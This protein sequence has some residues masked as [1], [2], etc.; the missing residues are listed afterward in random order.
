MNPHAM[1]RAV[2]AKTAGELHRFYNNPNRMVAKLF[3]KRI[4][5]PRGPYGESFDPFL[6]PAV[7][8]GA[9]GMGGIVSGGFPGP[10]D[11][12][13]RTSTSGF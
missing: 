3:D 9:I 1:A 7:Q 10:Y 6:G 8:G 11:R 4:A 13:P 2:G 5:G 12:P